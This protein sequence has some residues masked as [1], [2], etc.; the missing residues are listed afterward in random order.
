MTL[1]K[2][3]WKFHQSGKEVVVGCQIVCV[4]V[5]M[6]VVYVCVRA[7]VCVC[8]FCLRGSWSCQRPLL[9]DEQG[10]KSRCVFVCVRVRVR[11]RV[12]LIQSKRHL[13]KSKL[14]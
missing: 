4:C 12:R 3:V 6:C 10:V 13:D 14:I 9:V 2:V 11:V 7:S 1:G 5:C 8:L